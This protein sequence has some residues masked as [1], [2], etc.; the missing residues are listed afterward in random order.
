M[1]EG[2]TPQA[3]E[4]L[5]ACL[6]ADYDGLLN[7]LAHAT[8]AGT[9]S[10]DERAR[11][12]RDIAALYRVTDRQL[13]ALAH[14][15]DEVRELVAA[16]KQLPDDPP[17]ELS[18]ALSDPGPVSA[19]RARAPI[20]EHTSIRVDHLGASTFVAKGWTAISGGDYARA[21]EALGRALALSPDDPEANALLGWALMHQERLDEAREISA[22]VLARSP[23]FALA[24]VNLGYISLRQG[25]HAAAIEQLGAAVRD[26]VDRKAA[27][28]ATHY[29]GLV[30]V[31]RAMYEDAVA[32]F[33]RALALGPNLVEAYYE[34][35][36]A[37]WLAGDA[38][39]AREAWR[40]GAAA[41]KFNPWS[42]R[43]A[44]VLDR[45]EQGG[46][47]PPLD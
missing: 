29:L 44:D 37:H 20:G 31:R 23:D 10:P 45:V 35:G 7:A 1:S 26:D 42:A 30:Y 12:K 16:W 24:R 13:V 2:T 14:L 9:V 22:Q 21:E 15:K 17:V 11:L 4:A 39:A 3:A 34:M 33:R 25:D 43:C 36:R 28:Y 5:L 41:G 19:M 38:D 6:R 46:A 27:L 32:C 8:L 40:A 18:G 47:P